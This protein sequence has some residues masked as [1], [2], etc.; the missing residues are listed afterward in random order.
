MQ[1]ADIAMLV[2]SLA[3]LTA[4]LP[5]HSVKLVIFNL[6]Q[7]A[8]LLRKDTITTADLGEI[9]DKLNHVQLALVDY[10]KLQKVDRH[11]N[12]L[13]DLLQ[14]ELRQSKPPAA[15]ILMGLHSSAN[16]G[17][18]EPLDLPR[19]LPPVF[20]LQYRAG[21]GRLFMTGPQGPHAPDAGRAG[22]RGASDPFE[23][24]TMMMRPEL[25]DTIGEWLNKLRGETISITSPHDLADAIRH[26]AARI[27][28]TQFAEAT[29]LT[30]HFHVSP[31]PDRE[32]P[33]APVRPPDEIKIDA[34][35]T[36]VLMRLRDQ[37]LKHARRIP[38][39]TCVETVQRDRFSRVAGMS[40]KS[41]DTI[42]ADR[43]RPVS[44]MLRPETT[45]RLRLDVKLTT[46]RE[47]YSW[48]GANK[49]EE[50]E[51]DELIPEGAIG[52]GPFASMLLGIFEMHDPHFVFEG[53]TALDAR[54]MMEY[55]FS[56]PR[57]QSHYRVKGH[58]EWIITGYTGTLLV[59]PRTAE[60][61]RMTVRTDELPEE[62]GMCETDTTLR[63]GIVPIGG[64]DYLLPV[65]T[66]Q[67]FIGRNGSESENKLDFSSCR[68]YRGESSI[69]FGDLRPPGELDPAHPA[70][71]LDIPAGLQLT[72]EVMNEI[73]AAKSAAGDRIQGRLA[74]PLRDRQDKILLAAG[75]MFDGRLM[76][77]E[78]RHTGPKDFTL[79][80]R[81][82]TVEVDGMK[83]PVNLRSN[84]RIGTLVPGGPGGLIR[85]GVEIQLPL[86]GE[87]LYGVYHF[88]GENAVVEAGFHTE[89]LTR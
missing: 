63:Y 57:E 50:G 24:G 5:A 38:N 22:R 39:H 35:P 89:W 46:D 3:S 64:M 71:S 11:S 33:I 73:T 49:F 74:K 31:S 40:P 79:T 85:R 42:L 7:E 1:E 37:V 68:E 19:E 86:P 34:D 62:T 67:R 52:T 10:R 29:P 69:A 9:T 75:T 43:K 32:G 88:P 87:E 41:C 6:E 36:E 18:M 15:V 76:R 72:I 61:T 70:R 2:D 47:I 53:D 28:A 12:M 51:I 58:N 78:T 17:R 80:L 82:E 55:S 20:Y 54:T 13:T 60:L 25:P 4:Q 48:A 77:T 44:S 23:P 59:D 56:V 14:T 45:D 66:T 27:P 83:R 84:H 26:M 8:V 16:I 81:W 65:A 30:P 21:R